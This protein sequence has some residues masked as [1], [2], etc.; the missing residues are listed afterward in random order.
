MIP[1]FLS[2]AS[3]KGIVLTD[4][5]SEEFEQIEG[6][7]FNGIEQDDRLEHSL[8]AFLGQP[9]TVEAIET[10]S[11]TIGKEYP[12]LAV[13]HIPD[14]DISSGVLVVEMTPPEAAT[15]FYNE[16]TW[17]SREYFEKKLGLQAG[18]PINDKNLSK[19][20][21]W[22]NRNPFHSTQLILSPGP[23]EGTSNVNFMTEERFPLRLY[24]GI[25]NTGTPFTQNARLFIGANW[26]NAFGIDDLLSFQY[27]TSPDFYSFV[28]FFADYTSYLPWQHELSVYGGYALIHPHIEHFHS[29]GK[30]VQGSLRYLIPFQPS[31]ASL[32]TELAFGFDFK[33][34]N[35]D[36]FFT[37]TLDVPL[38]VRTVNLTQLALDFGLY[39]NTGNSERS[40][41]V[42]FYA[43]PGSFLPN[44][45]K[46]DFQALRPF[47]SNKYVYLRF[48]YS[49]IY[50]DGYTQNGTWPRGMSTSVSVRGQWSNGPLLPSEQFGLGG[51]NT[52]RGYEERAF[53]ADDA[54][55]V[56]AEVRKIWCFDQSKYEFH[57]LAFG[58]FGWGYNHHVLEG[59]PSQQI[60]AG[61]GPGIRLE[62]GKF[63][64]L[65]A[66]YGFQL[67][68]IF[69][70]TK[71]GMYYVGCILNF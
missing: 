70:D 55:C 19:K 65:R 67:R 26:G 12:S 48:A 60:L 54:V 9:I 17:F 30:E 69:E 56:N 25:D 64:S 36:L 8:T 10:I 68:K 7:C 50:N 15:V 11:S 1:C 35:N 23:S 2:A 20:A 29:E 58:D 43:S 59:L 40:I 66:D 61:V 27:T 49:D 4:Q 28:S 37:S 41:Y 21:A 53:N 42:Q 46:E 6:V 38:V 31:F 16:L 34:L 51:F 32:Q 18:D 63:F 39:Y 44:Q 52:V 62:G 33:N 13:Q 24:N 57:L 45:N 3:F 22:L 14:Q 47:A 5:F 71:S